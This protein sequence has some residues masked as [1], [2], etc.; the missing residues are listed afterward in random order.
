MRFT[1]YRDRDFPKRCG[2][3]KHCKM[4]RIQSEDYIYVCHHP[5]IIS[6]K[7]ANVYENSVNPCFGVCRRFEKL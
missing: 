5:K 4:E 6:T 2:K 7:G 1:S 3:C